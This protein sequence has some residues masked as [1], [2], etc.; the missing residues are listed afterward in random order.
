MKIIIILAALL[1]VVTGVQA[2]VWTG[3]VLSVQAGD[4]LTVQR[5]KDKTS[6]HIA[7]IEAPAVKM[8][9][10]KGGRKSLADMCL[11]RLASIELNDPAS[12]DAQVACQWT[13]GYYAD[14]AA[15]QVDQGWAKLTAD[16]TDTE[17]L[18]N[19]SAARHYCRGLWRDEMPTWACPQ[20]SIYGGYQ[21]ET[22]T[23]QSSSGGSGGSTGTGGSSTIYYEVTGTASSAYI[24]FSTPNGYRYLLEDLPYLSD[25]YSFQDGS[26]V[27]IAAQNAAAVGSVT[28]SIY[29]SGMLMK[30]NTVESAYGYTSIS[31]TRGKDC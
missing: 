26:F 15:F 2:E 16:N 14:M 19:Q 22:D 1:A 13:K 5:G 7:G 23:S 9:W 12:K 24:D 6:V 28:I 29:Y 21:G 3:K 4:R 20:N 30:T 18:K 31:C 27:Y 17:L 10:G 8:R 25:S 11:K